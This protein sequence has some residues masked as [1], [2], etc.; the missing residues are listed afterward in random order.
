MIITFKHSLISIKCMKYTA[1][2]SKTLPLVKYAS[3][4]SMTTL[5]L[6]L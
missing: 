1:N 3:Y 6:L 2:I 5:I 4:G